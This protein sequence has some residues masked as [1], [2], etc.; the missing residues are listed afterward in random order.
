MS[1]MMTAANPLE[2][3]A[4]DP[5]WLRQFSVAEYH[6]MVASGVFAAKNRVELLEGWIVNKMSQNP[7][8][9]SSVG[10]VVKRVSRVLPDDWTMSVQGPITLSDS[11]PEPDI[12]LARG[13]E[14][15][16]DA[17]HPEPT[18]LG[19]LMEVGDSTVLDDRRY[20]GEL[21][22]RE[23]VPEFWLINLV[24]R[25]VEVYTKP[26]GGKYQKKV[27]F[28]EKQTVP[29]ILDG[30]KIAPIPVRELMAKT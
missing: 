27:E 15:I 12:T 10:R 17:R 23:K 11:E 8:H 4:N 29:L 22:A 20:K 18:D 24:A 19:V 2:R 26:R 21:Y 13:A 6:K 3:I 28:T 30:V 5:Y 1:A 7:P 9:R 16:Y 14:E 25:K